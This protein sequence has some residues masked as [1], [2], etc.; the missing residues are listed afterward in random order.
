MSTNLVILHGNVGK[1][2]E[3]RTPESGKKVATFSLAT[4]SF[5]KDKEGSKITDWHN[6]VMFDKL[7]E[8]AE[9]YIKKGSSLIVQGEI[10]YRNYTDKE[11]IK[12]YIT[13]IICHSLDFAS[14]KKEDKEEAPVAKD[15]WQGKKEVKSMSDI[16]E[17]PGANEVDDLPF[18]LTIPLVLCS[19]AQFMV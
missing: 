4:T 19:L 10:A 6:I 3:I 14:A 15:D 16:N 7:A 1:D 2:P 17:L 12:R 9:K 11:G 5:R 8:L 18:I 13:D